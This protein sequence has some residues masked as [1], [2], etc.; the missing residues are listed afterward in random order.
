MSNGRDKRV[1]DGQPL[2]PAEKHLRQVT[3]IAEGKR[4]NIDIHT[5]VTQIVLGFDS[6]GGLGKAAV[7]LYN[8]TDAA[9]VKARLMCEF[10]KLVNK[11]TKEGEDDLPEDTKELDTLIK[12]LVQQAVNK[13]SPQDD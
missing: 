10:L 4:G 12:H 11:L 8:D 7:Q 5:L 3:E 1:D 13:E 2:H 9:A 6:V